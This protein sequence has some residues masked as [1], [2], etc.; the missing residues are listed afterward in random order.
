MCVEKFFLVCS[1]VF[2]FVSCGLFGFLYGVSWSVFAVFGCASM[3]FSVTFY[4]AM[5]GDWMLSCVLRRKRFQEKKATVPLYLLL[6]LLG[7]WNLCAC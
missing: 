2:L 4:V 5:R 7:C 6:S 1:L 3:L